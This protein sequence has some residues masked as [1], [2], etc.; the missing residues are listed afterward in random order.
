MAIVTETDLGTKEGAKT[1]LQRIK[2]NGGVRFRHLMYRYFQQVYFYALLE[3]PVD[4]GAL[5]ASIRLSRSKFSEAG[6]YSVNRS[7][8]F[9]DDTKPWEYT[10]SAGGQGVINPKHRREVDYAAAVHDGY[11]MKNGVWHPGDEFLNRAFARGD[12]DYALN[13]EKWWE[14]IGKMWEAGGLKAPPLNFSVDWVRTA[15]RRP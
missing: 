2:K 1:A 13:V 9:D 3:C 5:R 12:V 14:E 11:T 7:V 6:D 4:T 10:I 8:Q 15:I